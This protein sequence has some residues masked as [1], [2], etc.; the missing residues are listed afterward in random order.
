MTVSDIHL[1]RKACVLAII[2]I[3]SFSSCG[4]NARIE[5]L[6]IFGENRK[7]SVLGQDGCT[8][9]P[10]NGIIMWTFGDTILGAWKG[11]LTANSTFEDTAVMKGMIS[12]SLAFTEVPDD[13]SIRN[14]AFRFYT[15]NGAVAQFIKT[16]QKEDPRVW[17]LWAIDG[18]KIDS[19]IY[20]YYIIVRIDKNITTKNAELLPIRVMGV[21]LAEWRMPAGWKPGSPVKFRRTVS[22]F[23][24][25][26]PVF[27]D[28]IMRIGDYLYLTGHGPSREGMVPAFIARV[29]VT[30]IRERGRYEFLDAGG[31]WSPRLDRAAPIVTDVMGEPSLMFNEHMRRYLFLYCSL[32]GRIKS[33][34]FDDFR[35]ALREKARVLYTMPRLPLIPSRDRLYYYSGKEVFQTRDAVYAIYINPAIYQPILIRIPYPALE[36]E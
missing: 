8:P 17:R 34:V 3:F 9:I 5:N 19:T 21:G 2:L 6:G 7:A 22:L 26:E 4:R 13:R 32:D 15:T 25:G 1:R 18:I 29:K 16:T 12:N 23:R 20:V 27:G 35:S 28:S 33:I 11:E 14:L 36:G 31:K 30:A 10:L 24:E